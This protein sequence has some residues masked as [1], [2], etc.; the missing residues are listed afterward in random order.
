MRERK[1]RLVPSPTQNSFDLTKWGGVVGPTV[2]DALQPP[3]RA[4]ASYYVYAC[5]P[6][7]SRVAENCGELPTRDSASNGS[8]R[9]ERVGRKSREGRTRGQMRRP[10]RCAVAVF[11]LYLI[12]SR[13]ERRHNLETT[14]SHVTPSHVWVGSHVDATW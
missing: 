9:S 5:I 4:K 14:G 7:W 2:K 1:V 11:Y 10:H 6:F 3:K 8:H 13:Q 12:A